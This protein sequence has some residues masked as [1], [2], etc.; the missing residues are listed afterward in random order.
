M[1]YYI[2]ADLGTSSLKLLLTDQSR[3]IIKILRFIFSNV[4]ISCKIHHLSYL[5]LR[6]QFP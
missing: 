1:S 6:L 5:I 2:G 3:S 4:F